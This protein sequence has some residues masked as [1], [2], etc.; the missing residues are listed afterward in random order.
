MRPL[1]GARSASAW[2]MANCLLSV[3][4][5]SASAGQRPSGRRS[6]RTPSSTAERLRA[7]SMRMSGSSSSSGMR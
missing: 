4:G 6:T 2:L 7:T 5:R 3:A 1:S